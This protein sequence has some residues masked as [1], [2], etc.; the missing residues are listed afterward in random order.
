MPNCENMPNG[1]VKMRQ[2]RQ[3][4]L[5]NRRAIRMSGADRRVPDQW[6]S[7]TSVAIQVSCSG[8]QSLRDELF[9]S[10]KKKL[11]SAFHQ[12]TSGRP[13]MPTGF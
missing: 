4:K 6:R 13:P 5:E 1:I 7:L 10:L 3:I 8:A 12:E 2:G 9:S 11:R